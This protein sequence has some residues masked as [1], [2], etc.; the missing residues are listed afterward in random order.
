MSAKRNL[1]SAIWMAALYGCLTIGP[2]RAAGASAGDAYVHSSAN[3]RRWTIGTKT[4]QMV[5]DG[6]EGALRLT[7][8]QNKLADPPLEYVDPRDAAAP[9][10]LAS[11]RL[12]EIG[13]ASCRERV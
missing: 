5:L 7:S 11:G 3:G 1:L 2:A 9:I 4:V 13:R 8:F 10:S 12:N 6:S